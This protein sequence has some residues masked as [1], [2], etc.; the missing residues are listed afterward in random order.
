MAIGASAGGLDALTR[1][2]T[3]L[4]PGFPW[5]VIVVQHL[6]PT[7]NNYLPQ[8]YGRAAA[9]VV[10]EAADKMPVAPGAIYLAPPNY[11]L[12]VERSRTFSLSVDPRVNYARPSIDVLFESAAHAW[13]PGLTGVLL[14]GA[15]HDGAE[16][17]RRIKQ[18]GGLT[19]AQDPAGAEQ[20]IM[21]E[22]AIRTGCVDH[23][24]D[25]DAIGAFLN[26]L[27]TGAA[28]A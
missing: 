5:P 17:I 22:A 14:T 28:G 3:H 9:L 11:H 2:F 26:A 23:I 15:N 10:M 25:I 24:L 7:A 6:H 21:P 4:T 19:I 13:G 12:L 27:A 1:M 8:I 16:G 18:C 20:P